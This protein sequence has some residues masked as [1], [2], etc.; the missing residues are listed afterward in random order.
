MQIRT[1]LESQPDVS[2]V[3]KDLRTPDTDGRY[4]T[5]LTQEEFEDSSEEE[6]ED[7][8]KTKEAEDNQKTQQG[9][10]IAEQGSSAKEGT[11]K[12]K[13]L[14][15]AFRQMGWRTSRKIKGERKIIGSWNTPL[16]PFG[17]ERVKQALSGSAERPST[18]AKIAVTIASAVRIDSRPITGPL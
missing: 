13:I 14:R 3:R 6:A 1:D 11:G 16:T 9:E 15:F 12:S 8:Q 17:K 10:E 18:E 7:N 2:S 4:T 5:I